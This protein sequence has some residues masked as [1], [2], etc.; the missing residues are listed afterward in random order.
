MPITISYGNPALVGAASF[1]IGREK[2]KLKAGA[3][4][5]K[6]AQG[7]LDRRDAKRDAE[8][9][10]FDRLNKETADRNQR[11]AIEQ[12]RI[13]QNQDEARMRAEAEK[14]RA[15]QRQREQQANFDFR[16]N[17]AERQPSFRKGKPDSN[18]EACKK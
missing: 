7:M 3:Q 4:A 18:Y 9:D 2:G 5:A 10:R 15:E 6:M 11:F 1:A 16:S 14:N 17:Q 13:A 12:G 8:R